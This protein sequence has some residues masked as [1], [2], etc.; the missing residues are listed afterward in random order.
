MVPNKAHFGGENA[1]LYVKK[2]GLESVRSLSL[3]EMNLAAQA[4][5]MRP[6]LDVSQMFEWFEEKPMT[7]NVPQVWNL[8]ERK[9]HSPQRKTDSKDT[10]KRVTWS[11]GKK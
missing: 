1:I 3:S 7:T 5:V 2:S 11:F 4:D 9:N 6:T 8:V 10:Q